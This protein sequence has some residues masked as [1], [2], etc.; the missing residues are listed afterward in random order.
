MEASEFPSPLT[1]HIKFGLGIGGG[2]TVIFIEAE[3]KIIVDTGFDYESLDTPFNQERNAENLTI[4]MQNW[5]ITAD[6]IDVVFITHWHRDHFGNREIFKKAVPIA[7]QR[8]VERFGLE[9]FKGVAE[10]EEIADGVRV[11]L[12]PGHTIDHASII[13]NTM[14]GDMNMRVAL[15]GD[16]IVSHSYFQSSRIWK[17]NADFYSSEAAR[18][19]ILRLVGLSDII[20]PGHGVPFVTYRPEWASSTGSETEYA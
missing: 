9:G 13:V 15:A 2:S 18:E 5:G 7:S 14:H 11:I 12:T 8:L 16:A 3:R 10:G 19:S 20:I 17:Y 6:D 4:A 1:Q